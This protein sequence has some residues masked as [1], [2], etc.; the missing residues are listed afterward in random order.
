M[1]DSDEVFLAVGGAV[2]VV[3]ARVAEVL[4]LGDGLEPED[5]SGEWAFVGRARTVDAPMGVFIG[6]N[7]LG[8]E[9]GVLTAL[10]AYPVMV[11]IQFRTHKPLQAEEARLAFELMVAGM[12]DVPA[13][14][15]HNVELLV[16]AYVPGQ[17]PRYFEA[18]L[19]P[20]AEDVETWGRGYCG[21]IE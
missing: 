14:L 21:R 5:G 3:A 13:L 16:A 12:P 19:T 4:G 7:Y 11:D 1:A 17:A 6:P 15:V 2:E 10:D 20:D 9:P 8:S 18:D